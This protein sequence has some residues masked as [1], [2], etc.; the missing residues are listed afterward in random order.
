[1]SQL[2][3]SLFVSYHHSQ[4][5]KYK[6]LKPCNIFI[7]LKGEPWWVEFP[8]PKCYVHTSLSIATLLFVRCEHK[9]CGTKSYHNKPCHSEPYI[10]ETVF[11][12]ISLFI[13]MYCFVK[14]RLHCTFFLPIFFGIYQDNLASPVTDFCNNSRKLVCF[15]HT[16]QFF[17][18]GSESVEKSKD[19]SN[20]LDKL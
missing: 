11:S 14:N 12:Q 10:V 17:L 1:M 6:G 15:F 9:K 7:K 20:F 16:Y 13:P 18:S 4:T 2:I 3:P 19:N 5:V 8:L